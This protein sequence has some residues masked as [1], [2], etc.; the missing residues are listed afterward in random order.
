MP[1]GNIGTIAAQ[2]AL[3]KL[4]MNENVDLSVSTSNP[5]VF[6]FT[7]PESRGMKVYGSLTPS[8]GNRTIPN[9]LQWVVFT[10]FELALFTF[11]A[12]LVQIG[13][14]F[15]SKADVIDRMRKCDALIDLNLELFRGVPISVS[16]K[17]I[18]R[19]PRVLI[20]HKLFWLFRIL[21][22]LW[23]LIVAKCISKRKLI[24]GPASFGPFD[25]LPIIARWLIKVTFARFIDLILVREPI[26]AKLL[27]KL[28]IR[29]YQLVADTTLLI[30]ESN[31]PSSALSCFSKQA[32]GVAPAML[33]Y[34]LSEDEYEIYIMAHARCL[35]DFILQGEEVIFLPSSQDD[36][37]ICKKII[38]RMKYAHRIK[39]IITN[40]V[41]EYSS[42]IRKLKL[43]VTTRMHPS[44]IA[45]KN[46]IPFISI[47]YDHKQIGFL[48]QIGLK[49]FSLPI[50]EISY[51]SLKLKINEAI[52]NYTK[53]KEKMKLSIP[54]LQERYKA[55]LLYLLYTL[56][57]SAY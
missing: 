32:V 39:I 54:K 24:L 7:H 26:S 4:L 40:D 45:A 16:S 6:K 19:K 37:D 48:S 8:I 9:S 46:F 51:D 38:S 44:L 28:G 1:E 36:I 11:M 35:D 53:I 2:R 31:E 30:D 33:R 18:K 20:I 14:K 12:L 10:A 23:F 47:I 50:G 55:K 27:D 17:L 56:I 22:N 41:N 43:L 15:S 21:Q 3:F 49:K 57:I 34:T 42:V 5:D 13:I 52:Q 29:N 25:D